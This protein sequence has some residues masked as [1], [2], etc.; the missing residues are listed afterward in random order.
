[1]NS[2]DGRTCKHPYILGPLTDL[3]LTDSF[4]FQI[5]ERSIVQLINIYF[6]AC[7]CMHTC[8]HVYLYIVKINFHT[9]IQSY[10][11]IQNLHTQAYIHK[12]AHTHIYTHVYIHI[13]MHTTYKHTSTHI[14]I[15]VRT[16]MHTYIH[17]NYIQTCNIIIQCHTYKQ[18]HRYNFHLA[19]LI[20][21]L[22]SQISV[23]QLWVLM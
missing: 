4:K 21:S 12:Y 1:M 14:H 9:Y 7:T 19:V 16:C 8:I 23:L 10:I 20:V 5:Y 15:Y 17:T 6:N 22:S 3:P 13:Y 11:H 18:I 2:Q